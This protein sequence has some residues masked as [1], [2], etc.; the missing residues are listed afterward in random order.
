MMEADES[1][2]PDIVEGIYAAQA[3]SASLVPTQAAIPE[4][5]NKKKIV[6]HVKNS[7]K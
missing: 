7:N 6:E 4:D 2:T 3:M 5:D 1:C